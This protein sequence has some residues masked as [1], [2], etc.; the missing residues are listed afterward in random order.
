MNNLNT[1]LDLDL[2]SV[3]LFSIDEEKLI[4]FKTEDYYTQSNFYFWLIN[5]SYELEKETKNDELAYCHYLISYFIF[6]I[7]TPLC[8]EE[9]AFTH[10]LRAT[11]LVSD[12]KYKEWLLIFATLPNN[13]MKIYDILKLSEE[14]LEINPESSIA[15]TIIQM[16]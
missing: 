6:I 7:L 1:V 8:Y 15:N 12:L 2:N 14:V 5:K 16:Y 10:A 11:K 4:A 3:S 9:L 13:F